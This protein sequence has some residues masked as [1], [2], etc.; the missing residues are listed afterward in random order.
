VLLVLAIIRAGRFE[1]DVTPA[2]GP[3]DWE[4]YKLY[5]VSILHGDV[6]LSIVDGPYWRPGGFLY[7]YFLAGV[8]K[9][10]GDNTAY[11][12]VLQSL[13]LGLSISS[14]YLVFKPY[15]SAIGAVTYLVL[16]TLFSFFDVYI[17]YSFKLLSENL[18]IVLVPLFLLLATRAYERSSTRLV[19]GAGGMLG[20]A[21]LVRPN[22]VVVALLVSALWF[23]YTRRRLVQPAA[24]VVGWVSVGLLLVV[25][26]YVVT[27]RVTLAVLTDTRDWLNAKNP[28][29]DAL[30]LSEF[31]TSPLK[32]LQ[33]YTR[34]VLFTVGFLPAIEPDFRVRPHWLLMW[35]AV[36]GH[37]LNLVRLRRIPPF[38]EALVYAF[39]V[40]YLAPLVAV[41]AISNYGFRMLV[42]AVPVALALACHVLDSL[43]SGRIQRALAT[44][45]PALHTSPEWRGVA[46]PD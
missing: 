8:F 40:G 34:R 41:A 13:L 46:R 43:V 29:V 16:N 3:E 22:I 37:S 45:H 15:L 28:G 12:Y 23:A 21:F 20:L 10:F 2:T 24:F 44:F 19:A 26:D 42:P 25:R 14:M 17:H 31:I 4:T 38:W 11:A 36:L 5:A 18:L 6:L 39:L 9:V 32:V 30:P 1:N 27:Q 33:V 35:A 7:T